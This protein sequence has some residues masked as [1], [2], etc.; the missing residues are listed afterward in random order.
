MGYLCLC[1][2]KKLL[3]NRNFVLISLFF[4]ILT[5][6]T[7][8][9]EAYENNMPSSKNEACQYMEQ[10]SNYSNYIEEV[11]KRS[12]SIQNST[13]YKESI[14]PVKVAQQ[15]KRIYEKLK[16]LELPVVNPVG[17]EIAIGNWKDDMIRFLFCCM[18]SMFI[19]QAD[20]ENG[21]FSLFFSTQNGRKRAY[22]C[23]IS[24]AILCNI[25]FCITNL[26]IQHCVGGICCGL[27]D[28]TLPIQT[29]PAYYKCPYRLT[30]GDLIFIN[31]TVKIWSVVIFTIMSGVFF[32]SLEFILAWIGIILE[33]IFSVTLYIMISESSILQLFKYLNIASF[34]QTENLIGNLIYLDLWNTPISYH[35]SMIIVTCG[36]ILIGLQIGKCNFKYR[37]SIK[38]RK[39]KRYV[40]LKKKTN[41]LFMMEMKK[42]IR[43]QIGL[44][45]LGIGVVMQ[46]MF[47]SGMCS[48]IGFEE[49]ILED[50]L[51]KIEGK[52]SESI[53]E[54]LL[55][56]KKEVEEGIRTYS[57]TQISCLDKLLSIS[58]YLKN[59]NSDIEVHYVYSGAYEA[60]I[61]SR[62]VSIPYQNI[63]ITLSLCLLLVG[64]FVQEKKEGMY[65]FNHTMPN[66]KKIYQEKI[67]LVVSISIFVCIFWWIPEWVYI[68][69]N[70]YIA[71]PFAPAISVPM[72]SNC[73]SWMLLWEV[74]VIV[75]LMKVLRSIVTG[76]LIAFAS[77]NTEN[78]MM[79]WAMSVFLILLQELAWS[80]IYSISIL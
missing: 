9:Y 47:Y 30:I 14:Y 12:E 65:Y 37:M 33:F 17:V 28:F 34:S 79:A 44:L 3:H 23:K 55:K 73:P 18:S 43:P 66:Y 48:G 16:G 36:I 59:I 62:K 1:E 70:F 42:L 53:Y 60:L 2:I 31:G 13:L 67:R 63:A 76:L 11:C 74:V 22:W 20:K 7:K 10:I 38:K 49:R 27:A 57:D 58:Q 54:G 39:Q 78:Y 6:G 35:M 75:W 61:G 32:I 71:N 19:F 69:Q 68:V 45:L 50:R 72:F 5:L 4:F 56:E 21:L 15:T 77:Y 8:C 25:I 26:C 64:V 80:I 46:V 40:K 24:T 41:T 29:I 51:K 52:Y